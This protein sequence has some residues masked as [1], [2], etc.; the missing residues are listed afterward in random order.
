MIR[1]NEKGRAMEEYLGD[2][3]YAYLD[4]VGDVWLYTSDGIEETNAVCLEYQTREVFKLWLQRVETAI[5]DHC[6]EQEHAVTK[7]DE[8]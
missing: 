1:W 5:A 3:A 6:S 4:P 7:E 8:S 2:G